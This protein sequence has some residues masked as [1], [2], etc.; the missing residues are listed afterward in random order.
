MK[1]NSGNQ[2]T[3]SV[4][5]LPRLLADI[6]SFD[7]MSSG[8]HGNQEASDGTW[9]GVCVW[10]LWGL[11]VQ[12]GDF[13][14][15]PRNKGQILIPVRSPM[16]VWK[17]IISPYTW[18]GCEELA[19]RGRHLH[20]RKASTFLN[21]TMSWSERM[22][23]VFTLST[24]FSLVFV[25]MNHQWIKVETEMQIYYSG[26]WKVCIKLVC[27]NLV[28]AARKRLHNF[29][30]P[31]LWGPFLQ[32]SF[33]KFGSRVIPKWLFKLVGFFHRTF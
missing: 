12:N 2:R 10:R 7:G 21:S 29:C 15:I 3:N 22:A 9:N 18:V 16:S 14:I 25:I 31:E 5:A 6:P 26:L 11:M 27:P 32:N 13:L 8:S 17:L 20:W 4:S 23:T 1:K 24:L 28:A 30:F 33:F 19:L